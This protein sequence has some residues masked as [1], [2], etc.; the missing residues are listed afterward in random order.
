M[1][2]GEGTDSITLTCGKGTDSFTMTCVGRGQIVS[3]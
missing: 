3:L 1:T 2:C